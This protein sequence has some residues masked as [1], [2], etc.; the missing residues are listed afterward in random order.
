MKKAQEKQK[1]Y[2]DQKHANPATYKV[3][4]KVLKDFC[5]KKH[6]GAKM[7]TRFVAP[8]IL[9]INVGKSLHVLKLVENPTVVTERVT[10]IIFSHTVSNRS[11][12]PHK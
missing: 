4:T 11:L 6:K 12:E 3:S 7:D 1:E 8:Y 2:Y 10:G 5:R 9:M